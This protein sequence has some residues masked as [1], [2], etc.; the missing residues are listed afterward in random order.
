MLDPIREL[1]EEYKDTFMAHEALLRALI[2]CVPQERFEKSLR[3]FFCQVDE[4]RPAAEKIAES[5]SRQCAQVRLRN[6]QSH[7]P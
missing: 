4:A 1:I 3:E 6:D 7:H 2:M 5:V